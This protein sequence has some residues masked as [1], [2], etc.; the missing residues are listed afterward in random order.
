[1]VIQFA[2]TLARGNSNAL[3]PI[4]WRS[5]M[6]KHLNVPDQHCD[7]EGEQEWLGDP[8]CARRAW[9]RWGLGVNVMAC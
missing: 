2:P 1:M 9:V 5:C 7:K 8:F 4:P 3:V 6:Q